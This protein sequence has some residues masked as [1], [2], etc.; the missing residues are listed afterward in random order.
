[1]F[2]LQP[3]SKL[4]AVRDW[5]GAATRDPERIVSWFEARPYNLGVACGPS[6][7]VVVDLDD[8]H[9]ESA[10]EPW[11]GARHG[12]EV[13]T[14]IAAAA[15][16]P[17]LPRTRTVSTPS[18]GLHLYFRAPVGVELRNTAGGLGWRID[19]R[20]HGGYV[21]AA[22]SVR[23]AGYYRVTDRA[24]VAELPD[25]IAAALTPTRVPEPG[26]GAIASVVLPGGGR[27]RA[28]VAA[29]VEREAAGVASAAT[30]TRHHTLLAAAR[31]LGRLV[32]GGALDE[33]TAR[34]ALVA[35]A[36]GY[37]G[38]G[39]YTEAQVA[40]DVDD[41]L[42]YGTRLPRRIDVGGR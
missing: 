25:W 31:T 7:L 1:M 30:G 32:G 15:G 28:Y 42:A 10:P 20:A 23:D 21:V 27:A 5:E 35:A 36:T 39:G 13:L 18:G 9:G 3:R 16:A 8:G 12:R 14:Q 38:H 19:T 37:L 26:R 41:G 17:P 34:A 40:R 22:S 6:G 29:I 24:P 2:P 11:T 4:P 33:A